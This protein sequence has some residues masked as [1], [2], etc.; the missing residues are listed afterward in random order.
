MELLRLQVSGKLSQR[1]NRLTDA[2]V[3]LDSDGDGLITPQEWQAANLTG[4]REQFNTAA[5]WPADQFTAAVRLDD[6][7][8]QQQAT[9]TQDTL[10]RHSQDDDVWHSPC[11][12][13]DVH[14]TSSSPGPSSRRPSTRCR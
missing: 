4:A 3:H 8:A 10:L 14:E 1:Y 6:S 9:F 13:I 11:F 12:V 2:F 7:A 5:M